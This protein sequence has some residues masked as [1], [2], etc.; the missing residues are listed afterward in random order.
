MKIKSI[1]IYKPQETSSFEVGAKLIT[2]KKETDIIVES[3]S[4]FLKRVRVKFSNGMV[5]VF[6]GFPISYEK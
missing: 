4:I 3:I 1:A 2:N 6:K 5:L